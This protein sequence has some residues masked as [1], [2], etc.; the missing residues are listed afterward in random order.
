[1]KESLPGGC[2]HDSC[3]RFLSGDSK[4]VD[5]SRA[6]GE[7]ALGLDSYVEV[8][9]CRGDRGVNRDGYVRQRAEGDQGDFSGEATDRV[10][11]SIDGMPLGR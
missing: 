5:H 2:E 10:D 4:M 1:M 3:I 6:A 11:D 9:G 8:F 7:L